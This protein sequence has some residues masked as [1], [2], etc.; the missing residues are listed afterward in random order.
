MIELRV[1]GETQQ[2][3]VDP[4]MPL[5]WALREPAERRYF[6][7]IAIFDNESRANLYSPELAARVAGAEEIINFET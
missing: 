4:S 6:R 1:N 5:L 2:L 7:W 3:D